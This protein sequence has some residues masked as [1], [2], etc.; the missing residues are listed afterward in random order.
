[1]HLIKLKRLKAQSDRNKEVNTVN[2]IYEELP[3]QT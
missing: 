1:M 3:V 2:I